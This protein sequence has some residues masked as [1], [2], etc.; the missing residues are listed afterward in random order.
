LLLLQ[1]AFAE[2]RQAVAVDNQAS[3]HTVNRQLLWWRRRQHGGDDGDG[4]T[5][6]PLLKLLQC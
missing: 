4:G 2:Q 1:S 3:C 5:T 6:A